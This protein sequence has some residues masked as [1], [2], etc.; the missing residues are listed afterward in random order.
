MKQKNYCNMANMFGEPNQGIH[1]YRLFNIALVD[2]LATY[3]LAY[4]IYSNYCVY[5]YKLLIKIFILLIIISIF[6][7]KLFCVKT[8]LTTFFFKN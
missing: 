5:N 8:T 7:H 4:I 2:L 6:I 1:K 3:I